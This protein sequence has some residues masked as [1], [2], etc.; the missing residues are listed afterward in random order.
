LSR[1]LARDTGGVVTSE[2]QSR[3]AR[4]LGL[5]DAI[6]IGMGAMIGAGVF[7]AFGP[8]A[9]AAGNGLLIG[10]AIAAVVAFCN[11][12]SS[13]QLAALYPQSGGTYVYGRERLGPFW[14]YIAGWGFVVGKLASC[15]AMA[16]TFA[17]YIAPAYARPLA[18]GAVFALTAVNYFGVKKTAFATRVI[19]A[20]V[21]GALA[22]VVAAIWL[23]DA[24]RLERVWPLRDVTPYGVMQAAGLLFFA[25]AGYARLATLGEEVKS[26][27]RTIPRAIPIALGLT[28][29]VYVIVGASALAAAGA[30]VLA[31][32]SAPLASAIEA[33]R[34]AQ[35]SPA[36]RVGAAIASLGA[37]LSL[38]VGVSRTAFAMS[39]NGDLPRWFAAVHPRYRV[40]HRAELG[41]GAVVAI[42][43][44]VADVRS[45]IGFSSFAVLTYYAIAN[46]SAWTLGR[47]QRS[48][49]RAVSALGLVGCVALAF[50]LPVASVIAGAAVLCAGALAFAARALVASRSSG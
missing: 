3:L 6:V 11:A 12:T 30:D 19:V 29:V 10:L 31:R 5:G 34:L 13:L 46:A 47:E 15:A 26:P 50:T 43:A 41:V 8:A 9:R 4:R 40:P 39:S 1:A 49:P 21:L 48:W 35:L 24:A 14:G 32:S 22:T 37:L 44:G 25:F 28:L 27:E 18:I 36:A 2:P 17:S 16:M 33:G 23:G 45:A 7:A 20:L 38:I 42:V